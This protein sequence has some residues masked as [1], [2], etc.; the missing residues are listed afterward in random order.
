MRAE[1]A[2]IFE[3]FEKAL[4]LVSSMLSLRNEVIESDMFIC[5]SV[6]DYFDVKRDAS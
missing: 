5:R 6:S 4:Y 1:L 2:G 3:L